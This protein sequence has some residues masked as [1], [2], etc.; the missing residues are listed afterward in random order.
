M[1]GVLL[2]C[3]DPLKTA[4]IVFYYKAFVFFLLVIMVLTSASL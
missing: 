4:F 1:D 2:D 3:W